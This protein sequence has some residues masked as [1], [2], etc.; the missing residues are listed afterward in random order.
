MLQKT[1]AI[2]RERPL[3]PHLQIYRFHI[4]MTSSIVHRITGAGLVLGVLAFIIWL[5]A[6][7]QGGNY[8]YAVQGIFASWIG[9]LFLLGW[10]WAFFYHLSNGIRHLIWDAG[11]GLELET[12]RKT[13]WFVWGLSIILTLLAWGAASFL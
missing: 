12:A 9:R 4:L 8:F 6:V 13:G 2:K 3:S 5:T 10:T 7:A 1:V 11:L